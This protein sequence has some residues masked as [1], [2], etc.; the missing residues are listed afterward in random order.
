MRSLGTTLLWIAQVFWL[1]KSFKSNPIIGSRFLNRMGL[2]AS[3]YLIAHAL[4]SVRFFMLAP[5]A[6]SRD[7]HLFRKS[8][9][10]V[11]ENFL[12]E[13]QFCS[14]VDEVRSHE[15]DG[16][17]YVEGDTVTRVVLLDEKTRSVLPNC[18]TLISHVTFRRLL[19][20]CST[21][22]RQ[23]IMY[24]QAIENRMRGSMSDPQKTLHSD[25]FHPTMKAWLFLTDVD[26]RNGPFSFVPGSHRLSWRRLVWEYRKS[27]V[28]RELTDGHS[29]HGSFRVSEADLRSMGLG[30]AIT[31]PVRK[32]TLIIADTHGFHCRGPAETGGYRL[33]IF[34]YSRTNPFDL[35]PG[36]DW[37]PLRRMEERLARR[38]QDQQAAKSGGNN[39]AGGWRKAVIDFSSFL[40]N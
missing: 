30:N 11:K 19:K 21:R 5:I 2:H 36:V 25:T 34:G 12:L 3:R 35:F 1:S 33:E 29:E 38:F 10:L 8:G 26:E 31:F 27:L 32:N 22:N 18:D 37:A 9:F 14:L 39:Q 40:G 16:W 24:I 23:P 28:A 20:Y 15:G 7:R 17:E 4:A 6:D 13:E